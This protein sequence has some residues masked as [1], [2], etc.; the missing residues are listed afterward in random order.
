MGMGNNFPSLWLLSAPREVL[1]LVAVAQT[2]KGES[3]NPQLSLKQR[4]RQAGRSARLQREGNSRERN[5]DNCVHAVGGEKAQIRSNAVGK[6][7]LKPDTPACVFS[8]FAGMNPYRPSAL[9]VSQMKK[10]HNYVH[11][12]AGKPF[13]NTSFPVV[14][15]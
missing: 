15:S 7:R 9:E 10:S 13:K 1:V 8:A 14:H 3:P 5:S 6:D 2:R 11:L 4:K 12:T